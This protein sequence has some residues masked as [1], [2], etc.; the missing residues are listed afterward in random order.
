M[1]CSRCG[2]QNMTETKFCVKCGTSLITQPVHSGQENQNI[3]YQNQSMQSNN[4]NQTTNQSVGQTVNTN[5]SVY[6]QEQPASNTYVKH[7]STNE[8]ITIGDCFSSCLSVLLKP[9]T[10]WKEKLNDFSEFK[11]SAI[12]SLVVT[13][14][15]TFVSVIKTMI[16]SVRITSYWS[17]KVTWEWE[18]LKSINYIKIVGSNFLIYLG[19]ILAIA[20][21]YY[22]GSLIIKKQANFSRFLG[23][24]ALSFVP[25]II[26]SFVLSPLLSLVWAEISIPVMMIG[27]VYTILLLYEGINS[28]IELE[29]NAKYYFNLICLSILVV[30]AYYLFM[31]VFMSSITSSVGNLLNLFKQ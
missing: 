1:I 10:T 3:S 8:K 28:E 16:S 23:I 22:I 7:A 27:G 11:N 29:G 17:N 30:V 26:C 13:I 21:V 2:M 15:A 6:Y 18:N 12:L 24:S 9:Y 31:K 25:T 20:G 14:I 4:F 5:S 19:I